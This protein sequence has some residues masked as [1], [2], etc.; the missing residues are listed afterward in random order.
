M[1]RDAGKHHHETK[2]PYFGV[3]VSAASM[4]AVLDLAMAQLLNRE[5]TID[6]ERCTRV[7]QEGLSCSF[8]LSLSFGN[9]FIYQLML[10]LARFFALF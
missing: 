8:H 7:C 1:Y 3:Q 5:T 9:Y 6:E 10:T 2:P 4:V